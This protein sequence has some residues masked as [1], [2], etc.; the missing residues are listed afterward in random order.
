MKERAHT[1]HLDYDSDEETEMDTFLAW[2]GQGNQ[3]VV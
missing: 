3:T 2:N 1:S